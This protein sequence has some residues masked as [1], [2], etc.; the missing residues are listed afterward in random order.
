[1]SV[2]EIENI[3]LQVGENLSKFKKIKYNKQEIIDLNDKEFNKLINILY[4]SKDFYEKNESEKLYYIDLDRLCDDFLEYKKY[5]YKNEPTFI[6]GDI[7]LHNVIVKDG[8][9][10]FIDTSN[11]KSSFRSLDFRGNCWFGWD[12]DNKINEQAMYRGIYK[13]LFKGEIP[14]QFNKELAFTIIYEFFLKINDGYRKKDMEKIKY[15]FHKFGDIFDRTNYF[16]NYK[17]E[18]FE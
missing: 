13:G 6:H 12:G 5:V 18:W 8:K 9:T 14:E 17:F 1:M 4:I 7:N 11:G 16:E 3:G 2:E 15:N 10:Y